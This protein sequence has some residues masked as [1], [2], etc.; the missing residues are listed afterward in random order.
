MAKAARRVDKAA[1][2]ATSLSQCSEALQ[3][4]VPRAA[5]CLQHPISIACLPA[6]DATTAAAAPSVS[7]MSRHVSDWC[8]PAPLQL[9]NAEDLRHQLVTALD[10]LQRQTTRA[11]AAEADVARWT[12]QPGPAH[13][14]R[15]CHM[16]ICD[17]R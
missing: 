3:L 1:A 14:L 16:C 12:N 17:C 11:T 10:A 4:Q 8:T 9:C 13:S 15:L 2:L 7:L 5:A 6:T